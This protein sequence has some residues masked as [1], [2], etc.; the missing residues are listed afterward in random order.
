METSISSAKG[1]EM[2]FFKKFFY[3]YIESM[4]V[5]KQYIYYFLLLFNHFSGLHV[6]LP[7]HLSVSRI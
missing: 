7:P 2:K 3:V 1:A 6:L 5:P 4:E